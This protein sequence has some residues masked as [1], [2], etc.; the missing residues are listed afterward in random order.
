MLPAETSRRMVTS[1]TKTTVFTD[2]LLPKYLPPVLYAKIVLGKPLSQ[3]NIR[4]GTKRLWTRLS[5][6]QVRV[7]IRDAHSDITLHSDVEQ[8]V[9]VPEDQR[10]VTPE[11]WD[12]IKAYKGNYQ[13][14]LAHV[15]SYRRQ[16]ID[17]PRSPE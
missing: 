4:P 17:Q 11:V 3:T 14:I 1:E 8:W 15:L 12:R 5:F 13:S 10:E 7:D 2:N 6:R 9:V 16:Q